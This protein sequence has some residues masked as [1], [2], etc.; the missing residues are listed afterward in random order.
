MTP[1][2]TTIAHVAAGLI[3]AV[4]LFPPYGQVLGTSGFVQ[5][6]GRTFFAAPMEAREAFDAARAAI[7][8]LGIAVAAA[9]VLAVTG[10]R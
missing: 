5:P 2:R 9:I 7:E 8:I 10:R 1:S 3:V 6:L 4:L